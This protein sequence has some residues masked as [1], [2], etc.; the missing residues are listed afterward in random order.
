MD[1]LHGRMATH[2]NAWLRQG[3]AAGPHGSPNRGPVHAPN[4]KAADSLVPVLGVLGTET[5]AGNSL[6]FSQNLRKYLFIDIDIYIYTY[7]YI[8]I[9]I[10]IYVY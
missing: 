8:Y 7:I 3:M 9:C 4:L 10:Y 5:S 2:G 1:E 6:K